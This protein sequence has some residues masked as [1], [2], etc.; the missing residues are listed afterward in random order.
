MYDFRTNKVL[1]EAFK[2][3]EDIIDILLCG[4]LYTIDFEKMIQC[5]KENIEKQ[6]RIKR[7]F[8]YSDKKGISGIAGIPLAVIM[9]IDMY[10]KLL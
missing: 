7:A 8:V 9:F 2:N 5:Q 1:E 4:T 10:N 3:H 6:R